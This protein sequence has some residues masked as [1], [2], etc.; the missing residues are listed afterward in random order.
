MPADRSKT[1]GYREDVL[2]ALVRLLAPFPDVTRDNMFGFPSFRA[3]GQ[4]FACIYEQGL[5]LKMPKAAAETIVLSPG[6]SP[7]I[8]FG[9][10][11]MRQWIHIERPQASMYA[12]DFHLIET[13]VLYV[14]TL[15]P[16]VP[17]RPKRLEAGAV[18]PPAPAGE[19][20]PP[21]PIATA[22][23]SKPVRAA[24]PVKQAPSPPKRKPAPPSTKRVPHRAVKPAGRKS[25]VAKPGKP[26]KKS[27]TKKSVA[28]K[29]PAGTKPVK[30]KPPKKGAAAKRLRTSPRPGKPADRKP[31]A[32]KPSAKRRR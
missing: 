15:K 32:R 28:R 8:P 20:T 26:G 14:R 6:I 21:I 17:A 1:Y 10:A 30:Q 19:A 23:D 18:G 24:T 11:R 25:P 29:A 3:S 9:R 22:A 4:I 5:S 31:S 13:S 7:F 12:D 27:A 16:R 2:Q